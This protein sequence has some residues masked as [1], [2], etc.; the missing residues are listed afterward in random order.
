MKP[1]RQPW[2]TTWVDQSG[3]ASWHRYG[4]CPRAEGSLIEFEAPSGVAF[5]ARE[6]TVDTARMTKPENPWL[7]LSSLWLADGEWRHTPSTE[8]FES[9]SKGEAVLHEFGAQGRYIEDLRVWMSGSAWL[10]EFTPKGD[11]R[12]GCRGLGK[13]LDCLVQKVGFEQMPQHLFF[14]ASKAAFLARGLLSMWPLCR[15]EQRNEILCRHTLVRCAR[16]QKES[17]QDYERRAVQIAAG[18]LDGYEEL[19]PGELQLKNVQSK[20]DGLFYKA[21][22]N[23]LVIV[24][25]KMNCADWSDG[26]A[27]VLQ[28]FGQ[29]RNHPCFRRADISTYLVATDAERSE[30]YRGWESLMRLDREFSI[31][32]DATCLAFNVADT[33]R[34]GRRSA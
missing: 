5:K 12:I 10:I 1:R 33:S 8:S 7:D 18:M 4:T 28:Y 2:N 3:P 13:I 34:E 11:P 20:P 27:Q 32:V 17:F 21:D 30:G 16:E 24:E 15:A 23:E 22:E 29:A 6:R 9:S 26:A 25:A 31:H 19:D 14:R